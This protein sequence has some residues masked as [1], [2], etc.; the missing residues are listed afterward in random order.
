VSCPIDT[1]AKSM[2]L[3]ENRFGGGGPAKRLAVRVVRGYEVVDALDQLLDAVER[4]MSPSNFWATSL[5]DTL[6]LISCCLSRSASSPEP[7]VGL[8]VPRALALAWAPSRKAIL[9]RQGT[10]QAAAPVS[11]E[12]Q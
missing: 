2:Q 6:L 11:R 5:R 7:R 3:P 4:A 9:E 10:V 8:A 1:L 12:P